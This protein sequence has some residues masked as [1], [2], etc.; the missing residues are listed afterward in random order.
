VKSDVPSVR[1][2]IRD[3]AGKVQRTLDA[4]HSAGV[5]RIAWD[6]RTANPSE[7]G[8]LRGRQVTPGFYKIRMDAAGT[9][10][11]QQVEVRMDPEVGVTPQDL[12]TQA[13]A[14]DRLTGMIRRVSSMVRECGKHAGSPEWQALRD[15]LARPA[16]L[17]R[18]ET[19][20]R[21]A[22]QMQSLYTMVDSADA[23]PT[24]AAESLLSEL[25]SELAAAGRR[26]DSLNH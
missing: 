4:P 24:H 22:E 21:L 17:S 8:P 16:G 11:E 20:P 26:F 9:N 25:E 19:G 2:E 23:S 10:S 6:L 14:L 1:F 12:R 5:H 3:A 13:D 15:T 7:R 18:A